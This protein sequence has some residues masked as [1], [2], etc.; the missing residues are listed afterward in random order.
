MYNQE[1]Y[2]EEHRCNCRIDCEILTELYSSIPYTI[3]HSHHR[4]TDGLGYYD[5]GEER[6]GDED[7]DLD[8]KKR[9]GGS[10]TTNLSAAALKKA[11]KLRQASNAYSNADAKDGDETNPKNS[12]WAFV[13]RGAA[14]TALNNH[15]STTASSS[16]RPNVT[17]VKMQLDSL[18]ESLDDVAV[19]SFATKARRKMRPPA[20]RE[21][22]RQPSQNRRQQLRPS[23]ST[24]VRNHNNDQNV[25][26]GGNDLE[27][28]DDDDPGAMAWDDVPDNDQIIESVDSLPERA[29]STDKT[30]VESNLIG[31]G[32]VNATTAAA[33]DPVEDSQDNPDAAK[34]LARRRLGRPK[35]GIVSAPMRKAAE[36]TTVLLPKPQKQTDDMNTT[37]PHAVDTSSASFRPERIAAEPQAAPHAASNLESVLQRD[38]DGTF[39]DMFWLD[40]CEV[41]G[42]ILLFGKIQVDNNVVSCCAKVLGNKRNLFCLP[43]KTSDGTYVSMMDVHKEMKT[44][45]Q[46]S[47]I[48]IKEGASWA[49]KVVS[50]QYAF[51]DPTI[52]REMTEYLKVVYDAEY[53]VPD[54][55]VCEQGGQAVARILGA[56]ASTLENF[57]VKRNLMGPCW[58]RIRNPVANPTAS[59]WCKLE[60]LATSPKQVTRLQLETPRPPPPVVTVSI[61]L[62]TIVNP[63]T[64]KSEIVSVSAICH[65]QVLLDTASDESTRHMTQLSLIRPLGTAANENSMPQFPRDFD[66][67]VARNMPQLQRMTNERA[68]LSRLFVQLGVWDPDI[69]VG[70]NAWGYDM[71]VLLGRCIDLKVSMWSKIGRRRKMGV[72]HRKD[73]FSTDW[74]IM[75]ALQGRLLCDT[76]LSAKEVLRETTYSLTHLAAAQLKT[77]RTDIEPVDIPQ[78]YNTSRT[79]VQLAQHTLFD[80]QLVQR[81]MFKLQIMPLTKQLTC[82]AGNMWSRTMKG[83]RADRTEYLLLHE[84]HNLKFIPPE[85]RRH[86]KEKTTAGAEKAKYSGGLVLEPKKGYYDSFILLLDFN[87]LY[88]SIIQEYNLCFTTMDW[89]NYIG[90]GDGGLPPLPEETLDCGV[91][92]RVIKN[93]VERRRAVKKMMKTEKNPE[94]KEEVRVMWQFHLVVNCILHCFVGI[95]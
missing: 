67:E 85:K 61:K 86:K 57:I 75:E 48:P 71:Q 15:S 69:L 32:T 2:F 16:M 33:E 89:S 23:Y 58:I 1:I 64:Q 28:E 4:H 91:L 24:P 80:A 92:P 70:H 22:T 46:P 53:P 73:H 9:K 6:L 25:S 34:P 45:L 76:Y 8:N 7:E 3:T 82:V 11:R 5:D 18:L 68:L 20:P 81:L 19:P 47:C 93:L 54:A 84:F 59:S 94:K 62:K 27:P 60:L 29:Q 56:G 50:R 41:Q 83:N 12:M 40:A 30:T 90:G 10:S 65:K 43:R 13:Q 63:K 36:A 21:A 77:Q 31:E 42:E 52:P 51:E 17:A 14:A 79:I 78:W 66:D 55:T 87:S 72:P 88:P 26:A 95:M 44:I 38:D 39:I 35:L 37:A 74:A 49:G